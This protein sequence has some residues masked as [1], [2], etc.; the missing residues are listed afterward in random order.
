MLENLRFQ[1]GL[2]RY[3]YSIINSYFVIT[4]FLRY[5]YCSTLAVRPSELKG[6]EFLPDETKDRLLPCFLLAPWVNS[7]TLERAVER[8]EQAFKNRHYLLDI[9]HDYTISNSESPPQEK[10][11]RLKEPSCNY[12]NWIEFIGVS[13]WIIP[14][15]QFKNQNAS[16]IQSQ[17]EKFRNLSRRFCIRMGILMGLNCNKFFHDT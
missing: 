6:L 2:W 13:N 17:L 4:D 10:L 5:K 14:C 8:I 11:I 7:N 15:V 9:D 16:E 1:R 12:Q 3:G